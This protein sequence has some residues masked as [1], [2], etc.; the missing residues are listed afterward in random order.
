MGN[1]GCTTKPK[2]EPANEVAFSKPKVDPNLSYRNIVK[3]QSVYRGHLARK[4]YYGMRLDIY[5]D[6][7]LN[8]LNKFTKASLG[9]KLKRLKPFEYD[10]QEDELDPLFGQRVF[11]TLQETPGGGTYIGEW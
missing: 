4:Q 1:C 3:I 7:V 5:H 8:H 2:E 11:K 9:A 10:V 6:R